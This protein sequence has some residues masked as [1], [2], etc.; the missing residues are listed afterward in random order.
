MKSYSRGRLLV[1]GVLLVSQL[2]V[3][4]SP[5]VPSQPGA[6]AGRSPTGDGMF[7]CSSKRLDLTRA[8][9]EEIALA[10]FQNRGGRVNPGGY[11][12]TIASK[13]CDWFVGVQLLPASPGAHFGVVIDGTTGKARS[14][15]GGS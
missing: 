8:Q 14:Y 11:E 5:A 6:D 10:E 1:S 13:G 7:S 2:A 12:I 9:L 4:S 15:L 3:G